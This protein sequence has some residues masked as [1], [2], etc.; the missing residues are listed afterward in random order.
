MAVC[1]Q[2]Y[3][4][5]LPMQPDVKEHNSSDLTQR[6]QQKALPLQFLTLCLPWCG[7]LSWRVK[8]QSAVPLH[9]E[10][11]WL[12]FIPVLHPGITKNSDMPYINGAAFTQLMT[13][14][15]VF[16]NTE[17]LKYCNLQISNTGFLENALGTYLL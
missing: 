8:A 11:I 17:I 7:V 2:K 1:L 4:F 14:G 9:R 6:Y 5:A 15:W 12:A 16:R 13:Q 10:T 3:T